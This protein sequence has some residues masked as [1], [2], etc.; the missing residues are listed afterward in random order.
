VRGVLRGESYP[1]LISVLW[2]PSK[3]REKPPGD[4]VDFVGVSS[5]SQPDWKV[6]LAIVIRKQSVPGQP[7]LHCF[8]LNY[9]VRS[10]EVCVVRLNWPEKSE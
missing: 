5:Y 9:L 2:Q 10:H 6:I 1:A 4:E 3:A 8:L 7:F